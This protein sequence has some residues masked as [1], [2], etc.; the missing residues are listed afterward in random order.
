MDRNEL[1]GYEEHLHHE[2][3]A[4][5]DARRCIH[6][7]HVMIS[8]SDGMFDAICGE[9]EGEM[10]EYAEWWDQNTDNV[11]RSQCGYYEVEVIG[12]SYYNAIGAV[13]R[14]PNGGAICE[15]TE[16]DNIPF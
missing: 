10:D 3:G 13:A 4:T 9:C 12:V 14:L 2:A 5:G 15:H 11:H 6:H 7:P 1:T 16:D 8:S